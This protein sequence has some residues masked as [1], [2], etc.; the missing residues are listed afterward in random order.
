MDFSAAGWAERA[1]QYEILP[2]NMIL[3]TPGMSQAAR[4][5]AQMQDYFIKSHKLNTIYY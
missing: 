2:S 3:R 4:D 1:T 5:D